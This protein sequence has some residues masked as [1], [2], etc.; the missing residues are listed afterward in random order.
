MRR[1]VLAV[2]VT[3]AATLLASC[4]VGPSSRPPLATIGE[5]PAPTGSTAASA[6]PLGPGGTGQQ[7][8]PLDWEN[9]P[10]DVPTSSASGVDFEIDCSTLRVPITRNQ[11]ADRDAQDLR[12]ARARSAATPADAP[13]LVVLIGDPGEYGTVGVADLAATVPEELRAGH[14]IVTLDVRGTPGSWDGERCFGDDAL[15][16]MLGPPADA[17]TEQGSD[18]IDTISKAV[19]FDCADTERTRITDIS[20]TAAAD[21]LD[22]LRA[23][24]GVDR[25]SFLGRGFGA[26]LGAVWAHRY[27]GRVER[28]VLDSPTDP[29]ADAAASA[30]TRAV[31]LEASLT[32][33]ADD[34]TSQPGDCPLGD[35]PRARVTG[36]VDALGD[37]GRAAD[38]VLVT[39]GSVL[40]VLASRLGDPDGWPRLAEALAALADDD[41][42]PV[43]GLLAAVNSDPDGDDLLEPR[44]EFRCN[45]SAQRLFGAALREAATAA[46]EKAPLFGGFLV[47]QAGLCGAWPSSTN[48]PGRL[49][50]AGAPPILVAAS[51][52]DPVAPYAGAQSVSRQLASAS[53]ITWQSG[54][55]GSVP[56]SGCVSGAVVQYLTAGTLP[57]SGRLCPP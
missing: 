6:P 26:T 33:F 50:G 57:P 1:C 5:P 30:T 4:S 37:S 22:T 41:P 55:H 52:D 10:A 28:L 14:P 9:C 20:T 35:D 40:L 19:V 31:A 15:G 36:L 44:L 49:S 29:S 39:G 2:L 27:P 13:P 25:L 23:A 43:A 11:T 21:D 8:E 18:L 16:E 34:C 56:A 32:A 46:K 42:T 48:A 12:I 24:L 51:T 7:A 54:T 47:G 53:L 3:V 45:D 17:S 38:D